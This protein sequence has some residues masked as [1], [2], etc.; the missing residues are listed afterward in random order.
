MI[1]SCYLVIPT[2]RNAWGYSNIAAVP[3]VRQC[4]SVLSRFDL[5]NTIEIKPLQLCAPS[6][7]HYEERMN[8]LILNIR[9]QG[10]DGHIWK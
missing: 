4:V 8:L 3:A 9:R 1:V 2:Q 5:V 10:D 6:S 7:V